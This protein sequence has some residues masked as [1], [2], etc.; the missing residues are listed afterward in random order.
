M[1]K[2]KTA[3]SLDDVGAFTVS[4]SAGDVIF[5]E[6]ETSAEMY[7]IIDGLIELERQVGGEARTVGRLDPGEVFGETSLLAEGPREVTAKAARDYRLL[8]LDRETFGQVVREEPEIA[9]RLMRRLSEKLRERL[10]AEARAAEIAMAPIRRA[11]APQEAPP[12][13]VVRDTPAGAVLTHGSGRQFT[14]AD[15]TEWHVG[16]V[17]RATGARP[18]VDLTELDTDRMLSRQHAVLV[19]RNTGYYVRE[20]KASRNGTFVNGARLAAGQEHPLADGDEVRFAS[21]AMQFCHR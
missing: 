15:G 4:G 18:P 12:P 20:D 3:R 6:G 8:R 1:A 7:V 13:A 14:L 2:E 9:M 16:R 11:A 10:E 21:I 19:R 17:D 5:R